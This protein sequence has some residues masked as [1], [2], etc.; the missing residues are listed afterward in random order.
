MIAYQRGQ[1]ARARGHARK[2]IPPEYR[3]STRSREALA[4][5]AGHDGAAMPAR[6]AQTGSEGN[7][8]R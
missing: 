6:P 1:E 7:D 4:W 5:L 8:A 2:A 3:E